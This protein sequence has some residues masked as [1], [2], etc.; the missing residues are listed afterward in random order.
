MMHEYDVCFAALPLLSYCEGEVYILGFVECLC[1]NHAAALF[2]S[3]YCNQNHFA[4]NRK[5]YML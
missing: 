2:L 4:L 5:Q 3:H 1:C